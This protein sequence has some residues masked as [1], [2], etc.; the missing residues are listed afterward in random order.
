MIIIKIQPY[1]KQDSRLLIELFPQYYSL[2]MQAYEK[3][4]HTKPMRSEFHMERITHAQRAVC[5]QKQDYISQLLVQVPP[6][7]FNQFQSDIS[8]WFMSGVHFSRPAPPCRDGCCMYTFPCERNMRKNMCGDTRRIHPRLMMQY[9]DRRSREISV[10][11]A[12]IDRGS[13]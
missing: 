13:L 11:T 8:T 3:Y 7:L 4:T 12:K 6:P 10:I 9:Y 2:F 5:V 1:L